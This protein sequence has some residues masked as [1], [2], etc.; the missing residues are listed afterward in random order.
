MVQPAMFNDNG[1]PTPEA[2]ASGA[3]AGC[4]PSGIVHA[5]CTTSEACS[6][7]AR[8]KVDESTLRRLVSQEALLFP[9]GFIADEMAVRLQML[10]HDVDAFSVRPRVSQLKT[11]EFGCVLVETGRRRANAKGNSCAVLIHSA[12]IKS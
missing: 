2:Q 12:L 1:T 6:S 8:G 4:S 5:A 10:G 3:E 11:A 9:A 7:V